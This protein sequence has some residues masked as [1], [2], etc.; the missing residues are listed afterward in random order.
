MQGHSRHANTRIAS[1]FGGVAR[2]GH[3]FDA[4]FTLATLAFLSS[5]L[6]GP[7]RHAREHRALLK[8]LAH[9]CK[10]VVDTRNR[11]ISA[12]TVLQRAWRHHWVRRLRKLERGETDIWLL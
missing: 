6:L 4:N 9:D 8:R 3:F 10:T 12:A 11:V 1:I 5:R 7:S 2:A